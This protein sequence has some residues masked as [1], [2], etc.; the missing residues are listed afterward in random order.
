MLE[1]KLDQGLVAGHGGVVSGKVCV[2]VKKGTLAQHLEVRITG[3]ESANVWYSSGNKGGETA[4]NKRA[5]FALQ[6]SLVVFDEGKVQESQCEYPFRIALPENASGSGWPSSVKMSS[7]TPMM[8]PDSCEIRYFVESE[9]FLT[10]SL[11]AAN[12]KSK[13][14]FRV[15]STSRPSIVPQERKVKMSV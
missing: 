15:E 9:L 5:L 14:E 2:H 8:N 11:F 7:V 6:Y 13:A 10:G 3:N 1:V 4:T 12:P